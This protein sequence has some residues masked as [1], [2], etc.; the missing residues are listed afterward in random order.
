MVKAIF[1]DFEGVVTARWNIF[2]GIMFETSLKHYMTMEEMEKRYAKARVGKLSFEEFLKGVP[3]SE[4]Y[5]F[6]EHVKYRRGSREAL[7]ILRK[8]WALYIA[9]NHVSGFFEKE[10]EQLGAKR[11]F[12]KLFASH[13]MGK[14]KPDR[15]FFEQMLKETGLKADECVFV[16]DAKRNLEAAKKLGFVTV[17]MNNECDD[18]RNKTLFKPDFEIKD[19]RELEKLIN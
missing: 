11:Y 18:K 9:S 13:L 5:S 6:L 14:A 10:I 4:H 17:W 12:R 7:K 8:K 2:H 19:L 16:D 15:A 3:A 1:I